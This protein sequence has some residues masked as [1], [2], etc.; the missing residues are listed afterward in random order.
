MLMVKGLRWGIVVFVL[1]LG[2]TR[3]Y[4][5]SWEDLPTTV[6]LEGKLVLDAGGIP[7]LTFVVLDQASDEKVLDG[8]GLEVYVRPG[9]YQVIVHTDLNDSIVISGV[10]VRAGQE[11]H[12]RV[13]VGRFGI[14]VFQGEERVSTRFTVFDYGFDR[15]LKSDLSSTRVEHY[16]ARVG[17]YKVRAELRS[18]PE[19]GSANGEFSYQIKEMEVKFG[20]MEAVHFQFGRI[21]GEGE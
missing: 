11:T 8:Y 15:M 7:S 16:V 19:D 4:R 9:L 21:G 12:I 10:K 2:C 17:K 3:S 13:P 20:R 5:G 6:P 1:V 14:L 18:A